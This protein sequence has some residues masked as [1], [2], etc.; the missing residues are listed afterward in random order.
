MGAILLVTDGFPY[1]KSEKPFLSTEFE[2]LCKN[3]HVHVMAQKHGEAFSYNG[4][5]EF[6]HEEYK[7]KKKAR[8]I[9]STIF[10]QEFWAEL[11]RAVF[12]RIG[13]KNKYKRMKVVLGYGSY[14]NSTMGRMRELIRQYGID[15]VY[16][17]W[18]MPATLGGVWLKREFPF[19]KVITRFH[20]C[21]LFI[22]RTGINWQPY[23]YFLAENLDQIFFV[24]E[25][26]ER[27]FKE[28]WGGERSKVRYLGTSQ[29]SVIQNNYKEKFV[30]VSCSNLIK[31]K[32]VH[33][34]IEALSVI[35]EECCIE[36][37]HIGEGV[38]R[39]ELEIL[40]ERL[41]SNKTNITYKFEGWVNNDELYS[42]YARLKPSLFITTSSTEGGFPV[43][44]QEAF[45]VGVPALGTSVGGI[46][47]LVHEGKTGILISA[48]PS[49]ME[50]A[51]AIEKY[52]RMPAEA[53][54]HM[55]KNS[56]DIWR[57]KLNAEEN[58][59][60]IV[61]DIKELIT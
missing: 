18:C 9:L 55:S 19:L 17:Y 58:A 4:V 7:E 5:S 51:K 42:L 44:I 57:K 47:E 8:Y 30:L 40:A 50:V 22:E 6:T 37:H 16:T 32:R 52:Y 13:I 45:S 34:I 38:L 10:N 28:K 39:E 12:G 29:R 59:K 33:L 2:F 49:S 3:F 60:R 31:L 36:W 1:G 46:P 11:K 20:G 48:E 21:D 24:S 27:Y 61:N 15:V 23:R 25:N 53:K 56:V 43:S 14:A 41:L 35:S 54:E 26:G